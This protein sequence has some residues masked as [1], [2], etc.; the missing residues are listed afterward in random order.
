MH[1]DGAF[2]LFGRVLMDADGEW[3]EAY[4]EV[5]KGCQGLELADSITGDGHKLL[6]VPY[7]CGFFFTRHQGLSEKVFQNGNAAYLSAGAVSA[8]GISSSMNIGIENS[9]RFRSLPVYATLTQYGRSGY[10]DMLV[11]QIGLARRV[12]GWVFDHPGFELLPVG[13]GKG[14]MLAKTFII[15]LFRTKDASKDQGLVKKINAQG[16]MYV[17]GT[18]WDGRP[19]ARIAVSNWQVDITRDSQKIFEVL[20]RVVSE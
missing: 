5:V 10:Q 9:Q 2:G 3:P 11:R 19:A 1:V 8:D 15:V 6:N 7:D 4:D 13:E 18:H 16:Q 20:Q 17:T 12:A 14:Q